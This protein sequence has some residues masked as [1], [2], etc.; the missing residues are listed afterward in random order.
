MEIE[1]IVFTSKALSFSELHI[2]VLVVSSL[3]E[4]S[5]NAGCFILHA[6]WPSIHYS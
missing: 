5:H 1:I 2:L 3:P 6:L 4:R